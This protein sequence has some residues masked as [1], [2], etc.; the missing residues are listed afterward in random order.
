MDRKF[1]QLIVIIE[2]SLIACKMYK[3]IIKRWNLQ[4]QIYDDDTTLTLKRNQ[5]KFPRMKLI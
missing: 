4:G 3:E 5:R 2:L 1:N